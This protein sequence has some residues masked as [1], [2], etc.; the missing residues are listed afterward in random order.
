MQGR[1]GPVRFGAVSEALCVRPRGKL[2]WC[3]GPGH[4]K[5]RE[6]Q[7]RKNWSPGHRSLGLGPSVRYPF[8]T[9]AV[10]GIMK[11]DLCYG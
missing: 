5:S 7:G 1:S 11:I 3:W 4:A 6:T 10:N 9:L 2:R 8:P